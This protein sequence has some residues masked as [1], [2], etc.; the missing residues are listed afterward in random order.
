MQQ[1]FGSIF[2]RKRKLADGST[3]E[4][5]TWF[6]Q[7]C[8]NGKVH[9]ESSH[10]TKYGDAVKLL[11]RRQ[12][13]AQEGVVDGPRMDKV[14]VAELL[15]DLLTHY[16]LHQ[17]T[18]YNFARCEIENHLRGFFGERRVVQVGTATINRFKQAELATGRAK[19]SINR[20]LA[21]LRRAFKLAQRTTPPKIKT[22]PHISLFTEDNVRKGFFEREEFDRLLAHL[23]PSI[24]AVAIF[25]YHTGCRRAEILNL[26]WTQVDMDRQVIRLDKTKNGEVRMVPVGFTELW[27]MLKTQRALRDSKYP[28]SPFVFFWHDT[29]GPIRE[30][31]Y[32]WTKACKD[33][34]LQGRLLHDLRRTAARNLRRAGIDRDVIRRITG[35]RTDSVFSRYNIVNEDDLQCAVK[36]MNGV[37]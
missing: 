3:A 35:H 28:D 25:A 8:I 34:G 21:I 5:S 31:K 14:L 26:L 22:L 23:D 9:K 33:A 1:G 10:S 11:K 6:I 12:A 2:K 36:V 18:T 17:P 24:R 13:E 15:D 32:A 4:T 37:H 19:S 29:G 7:Y 30:I 27:D 20:S 16:Q